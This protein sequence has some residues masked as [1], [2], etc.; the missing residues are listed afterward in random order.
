MA[1]EV[2]RQ[3][4]RELL[5]ISRADGPLNKHER[6][7]LEQYRHELGLDDEFVDLDADDTE[8]AEVPRELLDTGFEERVEVVRAM[9]HAAVADGDL[10]HAER[11]HLR[12]A[13]QKLG[14][15]RLR[16]AGLVLDAH[17]AHA[18]KRQRAI[19]VT[20]L[21]LLC[22]SAVWWVSGTYRVAPGLVRAEDDFKRYAREYESSVL[23][24]VVDY[25]LERGGERRRRQSTGTGFFVSDRGHI[26]TNAHVLEPWEHRREAVDLVAAGW[27]LV[28]E[29]V[30]VAVWPGGTR[31]YADAQQL[32][33][34]T[35]YA[36]RT[37]TL[38]VLTIGGARAASSRQPQMRS[39]EATARELDLALLL[40]RVERPVVP[41]RLASDDHSVEVL[42]DIL[43]LG[44]PSGLSPI[45]GWNAK[46]SVAEGR[47]RKIEDSITISALVEP[48]NS[49]GPVLARS[50]HVIGI[51]TSRFGGPTM[52]K[53]IQVCHLC[54]LLRSAKVELR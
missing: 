39:N 5:A 29:S 15:K 19:V 7:L 23:L 10:C 16:F 27:E 45:E 12:L 50:G 46:L 54:E 4:F 17:R 34:S 49:G 9:V 6:R 30:D 21:V 18:S 37:S 33:R 24:V 36:T 28:P 22:S 20:A 41:L 31:L 48:G 53:C 40:A 11:K 47:V 35:S 44:F 8:P 2:A 32:D 14:V 26:A 51:A 38:Q 52:G 13:A 3:A 25:T 42:D 1:M 43:V